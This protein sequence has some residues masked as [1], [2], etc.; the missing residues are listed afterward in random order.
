MGPYGRPTV[1]IKFIERILHVNF[2]DIIFVI[3]LYLIKGEIYIKVAVKRGADFIIY[4]S[5]TG[6]KGCISV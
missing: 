3:F 2:Y 1:F 6:G 5:V 4:A